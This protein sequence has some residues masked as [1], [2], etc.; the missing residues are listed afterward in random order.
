[1]IMG[2][3]LYN[4]NRSSR[5][6]VMDHSHHNYVKKILIIVFTV[7]SVVVACEPGCPSESEKRYF[8]DVTGASDKIGAA[9]LELANQWERVVT[10]PMV[11]YDGSLIGPFTTLKVQTI[12]IRTFYA[13]ESV[14]YIHKDILALA[15]AID[16]MVRFQELAIY[17]F[18]ADALAAAEA[19]IKRGTEL[20]ESVAHKIRDHCSRQ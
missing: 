16:D 15:E 11:L 9:I 17:N 13:P 2:R 10:N 19:P 20:T 6:N 1:M 7:L 4:L 8:A 3:D 5:H 18:D 12:L 14:L